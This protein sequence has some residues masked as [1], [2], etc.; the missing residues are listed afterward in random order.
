LRI[1]RNSPRYNALKRFLVSKQDFGEKFLYNERGQRLRYWPHQIEDLADNSRVKIFCCG[2]K[3]GKTVDLF[4]QAIHGVYEGGRAESLICSPQDAS[5]STIIKYFEIQRNF[6]RAINRTVRKTSKKPY[7]T[8]EFRNGA[9]LHFRMAG[10]R[11]DAFRSLHVDNIFVDE[12]AYLTEKAWIALLRCLN[13]G[14]RLYV[15]STP[16]G[17]RDSTFYKM[18]T[19]GKYPVYRWPSMFNPAW[20]EDQKAFYIDLYGGENSAGYLHEVMGEHGQAAY[21]VFDMDLFDLN[22]CE[23]PDYD[24]VNIMGQEIG[25]GKEKVIVDRLRK[26]LDGKL[27]FYEGFPAYI[28]AD[29]GYTS[30]PTEIIIAHDFNGTLTYTSRIHIERLDYTK[31]ALL[32]ELLIDWFNP[33]SVGID[34]GN[35]GLALTQMLKYND[36]FEYLNLEE[37]LFGVD[38]GSSV[39]IDDPEKEIVA[40][41]KDEVKEVRK[42]KQPMKEFAT[43]LILKEMQYETAGFPGK[44]VVGEDGVERL[45]CSDD[46]MEEQFANHTYSTNQKGR[47]IYT[48]GNDHV[49]DA[50][51][52]LHA[53][54]FM[55][56]GNFE[57][58][59]HE[60][61]SSENR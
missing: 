29:L 20:D 27:H 3:V 48:K 5:L 32:F 35:N 52:C 22:L 11:G 36:K 24:K 6:S 7:Y 37:R 43:D 59:Y 34:Q 4:S 51:R 28:G 39:L 58:G 50:C 56:D 31:Q 2:R 55:F 30:D 17:K 61:M 42:V 25:R 14:G 47:P 46:L 60:P 12:G 23:V 13:P 41:D 15:Y 53:G 54:K 49:P 57:E 1:P 19:S 26:F 21:G 40:Y 8:V 38:F 9:I 33:E 18:A 16:T 10:P 44:I 45:V